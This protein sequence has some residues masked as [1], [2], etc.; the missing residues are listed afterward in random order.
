MLN[1]FR[2]EDLLKNALGDAERSIEFGSRATWRKRKTQ[3]MGE[4]KVHDFKMFDFLLEM[5]FGFQKNG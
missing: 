5:V 2:F 3:S 4:A 1:S